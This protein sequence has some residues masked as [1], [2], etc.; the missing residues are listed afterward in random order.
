[1]EHTRPDGGKHRLKC[2]NWKRGGVGIY[3]HVVFGTREACYSA[4]EDLVEGARWLKA[5][6]V[7][8]ALFRT[9]ILA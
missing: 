7:A 5:K 9:L 2:P 1:M 6:V 4:G 3:A 8:S